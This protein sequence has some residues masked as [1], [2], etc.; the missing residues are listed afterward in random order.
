MIWQLFLSRLLYKKNFIPLFGAFF[1]GVELM[2]I[3]WNK[4]TAVESVLFLTHCM[5]VC[6]Y[7]YIWV[8]M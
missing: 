3:G 5:Y 8:D 1:G 6:M 2:I 7:V 4:C